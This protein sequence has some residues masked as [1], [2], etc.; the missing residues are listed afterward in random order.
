MAKD[1]L[2]Q[3][4]EDFIEGGARVD[5]LADLLTSCVGDGSTEAM[6]LVRRLFEDMYDGFTF[7]LELKAPAAAVLLHWREAGLEAL[8][9][10]CR[11]V[12][13]GKNHSIAMQLLASV[14]AGEHRPPLVAQNQ[15][16]TQLIEGAILRF[17]GREVA[18]RAKLIQLVLSFEDDDDLSL[19]VGQV[20]MGSSI[21]GSASAKEVFAAVSTRWLAVSTPVMEAF[22]RLLDESP[23]EERKF[24]QFLT[25][26]PQLL[27]PIASK[28][29][30]L[31]NLFGFKEPDF[32]VQRAD[33]SYLVIEIECPRKRIVTRGGQ[34]SAEVTQAEKQA[35]EYR[36]YVQ[37][38]SVH[39]EKHFPG[40]DEP[41]ALVIV[42]LERDL[43]PS[44][45]QV[46][47]DANRGRH[48]LRIA[49][50][51]WLSARASAVA[52]NVTSQGV[53]VRDVRV[54]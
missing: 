4:V 47:K 6:G 31:P 50:F 23:N 54:V 20:M 42:G 34:L 21:G 40:I 30:P 5:V 49:G 13:S 26:H 2:E 16:L 19:V 46:L 17:E 41:D 37:S 52:S 7:N 39:L 18:S 44:Q 48:R 8:L 32:L 12:N 14:A 11:R 1:R 27:D 33:G 22:D 29:W 10:G 53:V 38:R 43:D 35:N 51:D 36:R 3:K 25:R 45:L 24:Q 15:A 9:E 28:V